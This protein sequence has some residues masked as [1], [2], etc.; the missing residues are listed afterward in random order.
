MPLALLT[1]LS[2]AP[3]GSAPCASAVYTKNWTAALLEASWLK[4]ACALASRKKFICST[5]PPAT[6]AH[7]T[8]LGCVWPVRLARDPR[9][10]VTPWALL[11]HD[12]E[13]PPTMSCSEPDGGGG[14]GGAGN[15]GN[16]GGGG[17]DTG[18][19]GGGGGGEM[20]QGGRML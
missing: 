17:G 14:D 15:G 7:C 10:A 18:G 8:L 6:S 1:K 4:K 13:G 11:A 16:G 19:G 3:H 20:V 12:T 5:L 9:A 2:V